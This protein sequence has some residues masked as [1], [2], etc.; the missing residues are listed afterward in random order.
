MSLCQLSCLPEGAN[1]AAGDSILKDDTHEI[2]SMQGSLAL[3]RR[4]SH[5]WAWRRRK[6]PPPRAPGSGPDCYL[7]RLLL[8]QWRRM[9][10]DHKIVFV[11]QPATFRLRPVR[12]HA[13][14]D[15]E[16]LGGRVSA[17]QHRTDRRRWSADHTCGSRLHDG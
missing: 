9:P 2:P 14:P 6:G 7:P 12:A 3:G 1:I 11:Q 8:A 10:R 4:I 15:L 17:V 5:I 13:R 16:E